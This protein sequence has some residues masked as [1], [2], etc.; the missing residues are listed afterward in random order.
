MAYHPPDPNLRTD[1]RRMGRGPQRDQRD[2]AVGTRDAPNRKSVAIAYLMFWLGASIGL[3]RFYVGKI[4]TGFALAGL[5][6]ATMILLTLDSWVAIIPGLWVGGWILI[7]FFRL[8]E[9]TR[10]HNS[11]VRF[12]TYGRRIQQFEKDLHR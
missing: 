2:P 4:R 7:G 1:A 10:E 5:F 11:K 12:K 6:A 8:P 3:H 9:F